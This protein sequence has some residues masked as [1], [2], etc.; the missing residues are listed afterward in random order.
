MKTLRLI[1]V[2]LLTVLLS[3]SLTA[4]GGDDDD[5]VPGGG[6]GNNY[7]TLII[8]KWKVVGESSW[9]ATHVEFKSDGTFSYTSTEDPSY[10]EHGSY[11]IEGDVLYELFSDEEDWDMNKIVL[12]D[13]TSLT[14]SNSSG[15]KQYYF[16][17]V[18]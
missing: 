13:K 18:N 10:E 6:G 9:R 17:R 7:K 16:Q 11:K 2:A 3:V 14:L 8:G 5:D 1:G 12:L 15:K 4:C